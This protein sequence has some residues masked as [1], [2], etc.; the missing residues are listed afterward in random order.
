MQAIIL[1]E[2]AG[3]RVAAKADDRTAIT[4]DLVD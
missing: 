4:F 2:P 3:H 1:I